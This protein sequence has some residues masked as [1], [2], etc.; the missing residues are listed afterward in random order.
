MKLADE[1]DLHHVGF[2]ETPAIAVLLRQNPAEVDSA[3][4]R[5][6]LQAPDQFEKLSRRSYACP[7]QVHAWLP[8]RWCTERAHHQVDPGSITYSSN[9]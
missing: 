6:R 3:T 4:K 8:T 5:F 7:L 9:R 1:P 2:V